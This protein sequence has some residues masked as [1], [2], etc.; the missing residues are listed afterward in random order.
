M[1][2]LPVHERDLEADIEDDTSGDVRNLLMSL[3]QV[4]LPPPLPP[5]QHVQYIMG[6]GFEGQSDVQLDVSHTA[7]AGGIVPPTAPHT[8]SLC[9][10]PW[11][12]CLLP[13]VPAFPTSAASPLFSFPERKRP[14][15]VTSHKSPRIFPITSRE[16][17]TPRFFLLFDSSSPTLPPCFLFLPLFSLT[18]LCFRLWLQAGRDE[19][20]EVDED[21]AQE[22]ATSLFEVRSGDTV[23]G[24]GTFRNDSGVFLPQAGEGRFGTDESTF[25]H[26][27]THRNYLQLQATFK[28]Y[29]SVGT[30]PPCTLPGAAAR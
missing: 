23:T 5:P 16:R 9:G 24:S 29:E 22:D 13:I 3:L 20:Y 8:T 26:I 1:L 15:I 12:V 28:A 11:P 17:K 25:T 2:S 7:T 19:G 21:L 18:L 30:L 6:A 10:A 4:N 27:L 14:N